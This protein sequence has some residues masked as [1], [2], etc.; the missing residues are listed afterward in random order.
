LEGI[1]K[2]AGRD[3]ELLRGESL[4]RE[5]V[6]LGRVLDRDLDRDLDREAGVGSHL[7]K[8]FRQ[9]AIGIHTQ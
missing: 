5:G 7:G 3:G 2:G 8:S 1:L 4:D 6:V 9:N